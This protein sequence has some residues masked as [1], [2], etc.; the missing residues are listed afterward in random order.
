MQL[1]EG[2]LQIKAWLSEKGQAIQA[3]KRWLQ[4]ADKFDPRSDFLAIPTLIPGVK[5]RIMP[6]IVSRSLVLKR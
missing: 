5:V 2:L 1:M 3:K 6:Q 4:L